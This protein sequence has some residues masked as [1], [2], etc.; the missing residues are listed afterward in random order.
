MGGFEASDV[1]NGQLVWA[2]GSQIIEGI[3]LVDEQSVKEPRVSACAV[4]VAERQV[5]ILQ[6]VGVKLLE[7]VDQFCG[8]DGGCQPCSHRHR[9]DQQT[10]HRLSPG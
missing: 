7:L 1:G 5:V 3:V 6:G 4:N 10:H 2:Q 8:G 9:V